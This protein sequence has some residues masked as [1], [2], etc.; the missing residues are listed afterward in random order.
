MAA[1]SLNSRT[2]VPPITLAAAL[3][4]VLI[5]LS[6]R[7]IYQVFTLIAPLSALTG[8]CVLFFWNLTRKDRR[9]PIIDLGSFYM[10]AILAY[11]ALP[12]T[13]HL[14]SGMHL[15]VFGHGRLYAIDP[16]PA[17]FAQVGWMHVVFALLFACAYLAMR[18]K[19]PYASGTH[20]RVSGTTSKILLAMLLV[21]QGYFFWVRASTGVE[22]S[23]AYDSSLYE[24]A[25]AYQQLSLV[26]QQFIA[27]PYG[28]LAAIKI[29]LIIWLT[30]NWTS[31][32]HRWALISVLVFL[33]LSYIKAPG[34]RFTLISMFLAAFLTYHHTVQPIRLRAAVT[35]SSLL[36]ASFF[37]ANMFR[38]GDG[39]GIRVVAIW[40][41]LDMSTGF[42]FANEFQISYGSILELHHKLTSGA[43]R[44]IP[45]QVY[46]HD[47]L[48]VI[49]QQLLPFEKIDP[50]RWYVTSTNNPDYFNYGVIA[51]S[52]LG[53]GLAELVV[54]GLMTGLIFAAI[55]NWWMRKSSKFWPTFFYMWLMIVVYQSFRNT[56]THIVPLI[57]Y[58]WLPVYAVVALLGTVFQQQ[59]PALS[60][61]KPEAGL[62]GHAIGTDPT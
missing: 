6:L 2:L 7:P 30:A 34:G 62:P 21:F 31:R 32:A 15:T 41:A 42:S 1:D 4:V 54:R 14:L 23:T 19:P 49:P 17:E 40:D 8:I 52:V 59:R 53:F 18:R 38:G 3:A 55:H 9:L 39:S 46:L 45:W 43:L 44:E 25:A 33:V 58:Q 48:L 26:Q 37:A 27:H 13:W 10:L 22:F 35:Y 51:E 24:Q 5:A 16:A 36:M 29:G 56:S 11:G 20:L 60:S 61:L 50:V 28:M 12:L 47:L 57:I